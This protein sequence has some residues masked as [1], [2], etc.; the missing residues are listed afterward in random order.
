MIREIEDYDI[1]NPE[2]P[3]NMR[4]E[5]SFTDFPSITLPSWFSI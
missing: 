1:R 3:L 2:Q 5:A 4:I